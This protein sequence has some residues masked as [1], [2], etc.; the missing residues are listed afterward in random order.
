MKNITCILITAGLAGLTACTDRGEAD[1]DWSAAPRGIVTDTASSDLEQA[2]ADLVDTG[3]LDIRLSPDGL[4]EIQ[5]AEKVE[6]DGEDVVAALTAIAPGETLVASSGGDEIWEGASQTFAARLHRDLWLVDIGASGERQIEP[7]ETDD[8]NDADVEALLRGYLFALGAR[9]QEIGTVDVRPFLSQARGEEDDY[10]DPIV[11]VGKAAF[12]TRE[13]GGIPVRGNRFHVTVTPQGELDRVKGRWTPIDYAHSVLTAGIT[14]KEV[15]AR[16][17][18]ELAEVGVDV[19]RAPQITIGTAYR[20]VED[21][22]HGEIVII[23]GFASANYHAEPG[24]GDDVGLPEADQPV[25]FD[26][27]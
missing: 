23:T 6:F 24:L 19:D 14:E 17:V 16:A 5:A 15:V 20:I 12:V 22:A 10:A 13:I 21:P 1:V 11:M 7:T 8:V 3:A 2:I 9:E 26:L 4:G 18:T 25:S 27:Q